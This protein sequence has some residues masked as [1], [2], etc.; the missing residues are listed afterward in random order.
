MKAVKGYRIEKLISRRWTGRSVL[1]VENPVTVAVAGFIATV[2]DSI[3]SHPEQILCER[4]G[5]DRPVTPESY[6]QNV[7]QP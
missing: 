7:I 3:G 6:T 2:R 5:I 1:R 4:F